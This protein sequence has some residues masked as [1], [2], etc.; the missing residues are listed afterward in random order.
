[1][2]SYNVDW[3]LNSFLHDYNTGFIAY[4][5]MNWID[6]A[7]GTPFDNQDILRVVFRAAFNLTTT[8]PTYNTPYQVWWT[9]TQAK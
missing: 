3:D 6:T 4:T 8:P 7:S 5:N 2:P 1:M 9:I